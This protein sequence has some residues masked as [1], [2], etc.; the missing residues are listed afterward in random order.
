MGRNQVPENY[1]NNRKGIKFKTHHLKDFV[2]FDLFIFGWFEDKLF[3][4]RSEI[5]FIENIKSLVLN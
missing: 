1:L 4:G 2:W 3:H 5:V